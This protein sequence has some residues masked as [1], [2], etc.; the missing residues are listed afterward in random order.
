MFKS[1]TYRTII[2]NSVCDFLIKMHKHIG[3]FKDPFFYKYALKKL[4]HICM[5]C[6]TYEDHC[7]LIEYML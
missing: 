6:I 3:L 5:D 1:S 2:S 4:Y 7:N